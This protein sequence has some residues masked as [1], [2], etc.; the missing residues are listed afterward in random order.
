MINPLERYIKDKVRE[1][2]EEN[3]RDK[4]RRE[5]VE[6]NKKRQESII[7]KFNSGVN[8]LTDSR[9]NYITAY[10]HNKVAEAI[11]NFNNSTQGLCPEQKIAGLCKVYDISLLDVENYGRG[12]KD[13]YPVIGFKDTESRGS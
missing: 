7:E 4:V 10:R 1:V 9:C 11:D 8:E 13:M 3:Y 12:F 6:N 5:Q 2:L